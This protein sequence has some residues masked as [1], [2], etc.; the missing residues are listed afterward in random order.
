LTERCRAAP[1]TVVNVQAAQAHLNPR[2]PISASSRDRDHVQSMRRSL[3]GR[4]ARG[5]AASL[6]PCPIRCRYLRIRGRRAEPPAAKQERSGA[7]P[8]T[9][10]LT[11]AE[12][13]AQQAE[14]Q[15]A[16]KEA[17]VRGA[18]YLKWWRRDAITQAKPPDDVNT[19]ITTLESLA[20]FMQRSI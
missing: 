16:E 11:V 5:G 19:I 18:T 12:A 13:T 14:W 2:D 8:T 3:L 20:G 6:F 1:P 15:D 7:Q 17:L 4:R 9:E 10:T